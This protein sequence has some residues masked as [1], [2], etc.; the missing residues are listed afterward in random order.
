MNSLP[1]CRV[2]KKF[3]KC[4]SSAEHK[5]LI[6]AWFACE[7]TSSFESRTLGIDLMQKADDKMDTILWISFV[8]YNHLFQK[9]WQPANTICV[10]LKM[11]WATSQRTWQALKVVKSRRRISKWQQIKWLVLLPPPSKYGEIW[12]VWCAEEGVSFLVWYRFH[13]WTHFEMRLAL[14]YMSVW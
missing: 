10:S 3:E 12:R 4:E 2:K 14:G 9:P 1:L 5:M 7:V 6:N 11:K 13:W 8:F